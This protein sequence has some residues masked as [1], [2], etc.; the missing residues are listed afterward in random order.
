MSRAH[1][2]SRSSRVPE[3]RRSRSLSTRRG[4]RSRPSPAAL[5]VV[6]V[7]ADFS[8]EF[9]T[10]VASSTEA[11]A[12]LCRTGDALLQEIE[13]HVLATFEVPHH[14]ATAFADL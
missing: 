2:E 5:G 12:S 14:V 11:Y 9:P 4:G 8:A 7:D 1:R 13:R 3:L 6:K 10:A